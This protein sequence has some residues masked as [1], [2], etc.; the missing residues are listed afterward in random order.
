MA[1]RIRVISIGAIAAHPVWGEK[2][3]VRPAH[4][5]TTL[6]EAG[7]SCIVVDPSLP[8]QVLIPRL[9]ER[10]G[11][12]PKDITHVFLTSFHPM[13]RRGL[14]AFPDAEVLLAATEREGVAEQLKQRLQQAQHHADVEVERMVSEELAM[15]RNCQDAPDRLEEGVDLFPLPG[16]TPGNS[17]LLVP[18]TSNTLLITGDAIATAEHLEKGMMIAPCF[19]IQQGLAS[20]AEV[21]EI[22]DLIVPGRDNLFANPIRRF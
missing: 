4:A 17:G 8:A 14:A 19:D 22:A 6:L 7:K 21:I 5:T 13:R 16:V 2:S 3:E 1:V 18:S 15:L 12:S 9:A 11:K 10:S 20:L